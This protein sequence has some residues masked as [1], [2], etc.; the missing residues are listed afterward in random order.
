MGVKVTCPVYEGFI[1][2]FHDMREDH[3]TTRRIV[4][5]YARDVWG[6][7]PAFEMIEKIVDALEALL[8]LQV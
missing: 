2:Q 3:G 8:D 5:R 7:R 4:D 1:T 6:W